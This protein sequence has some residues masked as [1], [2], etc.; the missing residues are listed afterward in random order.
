MSALVLLMAVAALGGW[1]DTMDTGALDGYF[2]I[3]ELSGL[4]QDLEESFTELEVTK[5]TLMG[6]EIEYLVVSA[7]SGITNK[8]QVIVSAGQFAGFPNGPQMVAYLMNKLT[9]DSNELNSLLL[10]IRVYFIPILNR[11]G[12]AAME[13]AYDTDKFKRYYTNLKDTG[14]SSGVQGVNLNRNWPKEFI[15]SEDE[16]CTENYAGTAALS[17]A[18]TSAVAT[19]LIDQNTFSLWIHYDRSENILKAYSY[20]SSVDITDLNV[21]SLY[22]YLE[23]TLGMDLTSA[24]NSESGSLIDY[25]VSK[26]MGSIEI[27]LSGENTQIKETLAAHETLALSILSLASYSLTELAIESTDKDCGTEYTCSIDTNGIYAL[28]TMSL[29]NNGMTDTSFTFKIDTTGDPYRVTTIKVE[30]QKL[31]DSTDRKEQSLTGINTSSSTFDQVVLRSVSKCVFSVYVELSNATRRELAISDEKLTVNYYPDGVDESGSLTTTVI[32]SDGE[33]SVDNARDGLY[34][35]TITGIIIAIIVIL[36]VAGLMAL[37]ILRNRR[38]EE[39]S[40][41]EEPRM[42]IPGVIHSQKMFG[43]QDRV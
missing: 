8:A 13:G 23:G 14:C 10:K 31:K 42:D 16:K 39:D 2:N 15:G 22:E 19:K 3:T 41:E 20:N 6:S 29:T 35:I 33:G 26:A 1:E 36:A 40:E 11:K 21:V 30:C 24:G 32:H 37:F 4:M 28:Y 17:E 18:E 7:K 27:G 43:G 25:A 38:M 34:G 12:F 9:A 5:S